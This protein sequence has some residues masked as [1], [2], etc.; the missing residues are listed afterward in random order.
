MIFVRTG[1]GHKQGWAFGLGLERIAMVLFSIPDIRLFWSQDD[2][3]LS[4]FRAG[5]ISTFK[6]Y[7]KYPECYKDLAFWLPDNGEVVRSGGKEWHE[8]DFMEVVRDEAGDLVEG[9]QLVSR[10]PS[11]PQDC[12]R[13]SPLRAVEHPA[14]A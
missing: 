6:P 10:M 11:E 2:R 7:S 3:F 12:F 1:V 13:G 5:E 8:N 14:M 4:Q 9:V